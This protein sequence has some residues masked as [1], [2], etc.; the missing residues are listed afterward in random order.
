MKKLSTL[1]CAL[2]LGTVLLR[3]QAPTQPN[4]VLIVADDLNDYVQGFSGH[5]QAKTPNINKIEKKGTTFTST[6]CAS[7]KCAP[8]R[9]SMITG[10]DTYYTK[11]YNNDDIGC[12]N[13]RKNFR[14]EKGN[15]VVFTIPEL[16]KDSGGYFTYTLSKVMHCYP[17]L[18]D[19]DTSNVAMCDK[20]LSWNKAFS[21][22]QGGDMTDVLDYGDEHDDGV[23]GFNFAVIPDTME[24]NT[25]DYIITDSAISFIE[26][27]A[28]NPATYCNKPFFLAIGYK[29]PHG[30]FY[31]PEKYFLPY[32]NTDYYSVPYDK[33]YND[34]V[35]ATPYNGVVMP[36]Q[37]DPMWSDYTSLPDDLVGKAMNEEDYVHPD[38]L[39]FGDYMMGLIPPPEIAAGLSDSEKTFI[40]QESERA[41]GIIAYLAAIKFFDAQ[42]GRFYDEIK[43]HPEIFNNTVFIITSDHGYSL[44]EKTHWRKGCLWETDVRIPMV[45]ADMRTPVK[46]TCKR[47]VGNIDLMPTILEMAG[48]DAP[49]FPD[50]SPYMDGV[51]L[52]PLLANPNTPWDKPVV[53]AL[54][55]HG[56][57]EG[58]CFPQYSVRDEE[59]H[60]IRYQTNG[61]TA[62]ACNE[63]LSVFQEELYRIG[64]NKNIDPYEWNN[65]ADNPAYDDVKA[66]LASFLP[67]GVNYL[68][69]DRTASAD[70][71]AMAVQAF[72]V[73]PN[74]TSEYANFRMEGF[75]PGAATLQ[76]TDLMGRI[77]RN[78][79]VT[80]DENGYLE[81][82]YNVTT[83]QQGYYI[84][85]VI[86][87]N[88]SMQTEFIVAR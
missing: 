77:I 6:Y 28:S 84:G 19:Y 20:G 36:P 7:P 44:G 40:L 22:G 23:T 87:G 35:G 37:P 48:V 60:Y 59:Y 55:L 12:K 15:E 68:Q 56:Y 14:E 51:S 71:A 81:V 8:S 29:R 80:V 21:Y 53:S 26:D 88:D 82:S 46:K 66:H 75:T 70:D 11:V 65:L 78:D 2:V 54:Q 24:D 45:I 86:Q 62:P 43:S 50:G 27:Y 63:A 32:Y 73:F 13:F 41:N 38:F 58:F 64:K 25:V 76:I 10:K 4:F 57:A 18:P 79:E 52:T 39:E 42:V 17:G 72:G 30:P 69:F 83:I 34:P 49:T 1:L 9:T 33:P 74:P 31:V 16:L 67:G 5:P 47:V 85:R 61:A 3:A